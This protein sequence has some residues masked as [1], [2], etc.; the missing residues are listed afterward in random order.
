MS[1]PISSV[2]AANKISVA[3][4]KQ[5]KFLG[6][7]GSSFDTLLAQ[8]TQMGVSS[9]E[10]MKASESA[11]AP[12]LDSR[13]ANSGS[14][15]IGR[16]ENY[17]EQTG[18]PLER[19]EV[20]PSGREKL[21]RVLEES[22]YSEEDAK[23]IVKRA[24]KDDGSINL[25]TVFQ[26]LEHYEADQ[27]PVLIID[28]SQKNQFIQILQE[29][30]LKQEDIQKF[31]AENTNKDGNLEIK[32]FGE[33]LAKVEGAQEGQAVN[34]GVNKSI[35][36]GLLEQLGLSDEEITTLLEQNTDTEG[37]I[38]AEAALNILKK[39]AAK[40][41][42]AVAQAMK[43]LA[44]D[45]KVKST[46]NE[47]DFS[48][49]DAKRIKQQ[50]EKIIQAMEGN[51]GHSKSSLKEALA[52]AMADE[53]DDEMTDVKPQALTGQEQNAAPK[54]KATA[55]TAASEDKQQAYQFAK[56]QSVQA[57]AETAGQ[58]AQSGNTNSS[59]SGG[60]P[61]AGIENA[62][63]TA[64]SGKATAARGP[65]PS[66][67]VNQVAD[68]L[69]YMVKNNQNSLKINIKPPELGELNV[70]L[71]MKDGVL[72]ATLTAESVAAKNTLDAGSE[73]LKQLLAQQGI[74]VE[75]LDI[76]LK[77]DSQE[78]QAQF[79]DHL[80]KKGGYQSGGK[81]TGQGSDV[82][83]TDLTAAVS[84]QRLGSSGS[85]SVFA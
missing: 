55:D 36:S 84:K 12:E 38:Q 64:E 28:A 18:E 41:N 68:R 71:S 59:K 40:K 39:A 66:Y 52:A 26:L 33:L 3:A 79:E 8:I 62:G 75:S 83:E 85:I 16:L 70:E 48:Q 43:D 49:A 46:D 14:S 61:T 69:A 76:T 31:L 15:P 17:L 24:T 30:G 7:P 72:K 21:V 29:L 22:G 5:L 25:G 23:E 37:N 10:I 60:N 47:V 2:D 35:L 80:N 51:E 50:A 82:E 58:D 65:L 74:K 20:S 78:S 6:S 57:K 77:S 44:A 42:Q 56:E 19:F 4:H 53:F 73:Q 63:R 67:V 32:N 27:G 81:S 11:S 54:V 45:L 9:Q 1:N 13:S 34:G